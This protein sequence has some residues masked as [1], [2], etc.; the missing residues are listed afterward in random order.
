MTSLQ[1]R[2]RKQLVGYPWLPSLFVALISGGV[3]FF[4]GN[5]QAVPQSLQTL[6]TSIIQAVVWIIGTLSSFAQWIAAIIASIAFILAAL[7]IYYN[8]KQKS[9]W[10]KIE[11]E[12]TSNSES[13]DVDSED[14]VKSPREY[15]IERIS[16]IEDQIWISDDGDI[17]ITNRHL[18][19]AQKIILY[20]IGIRY[21]FEIDLVD[22]PRVGIVELSNE[23][24]IP[25]QSV[26]GWQLPLDGVVE[27]HHYDIWEGKLNDYEIKLENIDRA[28]DY[29]MGKRDLPEANLLAS[30][31]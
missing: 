8:R 12:L 4:L 2:L 17:T 18:N 30:H 19:D 13:E 26:I 29:V 3:W 25:F 10:D 1:K 31:L 27:K 20:L 15:L 7:A 11:D 28:I 14:L 16:D 24:K 9:R 22:S 23:L 5:P 6:I 21:M